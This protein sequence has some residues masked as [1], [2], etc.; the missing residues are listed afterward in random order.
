[1]RIPSIPPDLIEIIRN[2]SPT[3]WTEWFRQF[4]EP[5][6]TE[7]IR[8]CNDGYFHWD[9]IRHFNNL[10]KEMNVE[11]VWAAIAMSRRQQYQP[12]SIKFNN[13]TLVYWNPPQHLEWLCII[14]Q[15]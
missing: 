2:I 5:E 4:S 13:S 3:D 6:I 14:D 8:R 11:F 12:L 9:K 1:M 7:F 15:Q 10:P